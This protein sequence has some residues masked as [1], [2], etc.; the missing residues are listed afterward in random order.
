MLTHDVPCLMTYEAIDDF[1]NKVKPIRGTNKKIPLGERRY[2]HA[3]YIIRD[4]SNI[5]V[6]TYSDND[7]M[8]YQPNGLITF[9]HGRWGLCNRQIIDAIVKERFTTKY[10]NSD[11]YYLYDMIKH[12]QYPIF[13]DRPITIDAKNDYAFIG[14]LEVEKKPY[15]K[16][17]VMRELRKEYAE[18]IEY[19]ITMNKLAGGQHDMTEDTDSRMPAFIPKDTLDALMAKVKGKSFQGNEEA[20][21][22]LFAFITR[23]WG[24]YRWSH[25]SMFG[26]RSMRQL[27]L[28][29][30][31]IKNGITDYLK[32]EHSD[33]V[34]EL[35]EV[36]NTTVVK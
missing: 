28:T 31:D 25:G 35:R 21:A 4:G 19:A 27:H 17:A 23:Y 6:R 36:E 34:F 14:E 9:Y 24:T 32:R 10:A 15:V 8:C 5:L 2:Y 18:F 29:D 20:Y 22:N 13:Y 3:R 16:R 12:I 1:A 33:Q 7:V 26:S 30:N 11:K